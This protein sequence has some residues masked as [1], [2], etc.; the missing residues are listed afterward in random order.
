MKLYYYF[1]AFVFLCF[2]S[3][4]TTLADN[5]KN[6]YGF[7][8]NGAT[9]YHLE[10]G[11]LTNG[12]TAIITASIDGSV[13]CFDPQGKKLW[14]AGTDGGF[15]FDM[16]VADIDNDG[17]DEV[18]VASGNGS[19]YAFNSKGENLWVFSKSAPMYQVSSAK[20][21]DGSSVVVA[22]GVEQILYSLSNQGEVINALNT[23][24][25]IRHIRAGN[26]KNNGQDYIAL[27]TTSSGL[28]GSLSLLLIDPS[29]LSVIWE[30]TDLGKYGHNTGK[31]FFSM[32]ITDTNKDGNEEI[33]LSGGWGEN[34]IVYAYDHKGELLFSESDKIIPK[35]SYRMNLLR[36]VKMPE[37]EFIIGLFG[38]VLIVYE[39]DGTC[40]EVLYGPYSFTDCDF[41]PETKTLFMGSEVSGGDGIYALRLDKSGWQKEYESIRAVGKL[42]VIKQNLE[43][44]KEQITNFKAPDYQPAPRHVDVLSRN[45]G[46]IDYKNITFIA[47]SGFSQEKEENAI[48]CRNPDR[49]APHNLSAEEIVAR[50]AELEKSGQRFILGG[51]HGEGFNYPLSTFER[52]I[53]AAPDH[54]LGFSFSEME[55]TGKSMQE[56]VEKILLP[57]AELCKQH[58]KIIIFQNKNIFWNGSVYLPFWEKIL[59]NERY[60]DVFIPG[61]E[62]TN[63][64]TQELSLSGRIGLWQTGSFDRWSCREITDNANFDRMFEWGGQQVIVHHLRNLVSTTSLG[65]DFLQPYI[66]SGERHEIRDALFEQLVPFYKMLEK[67]IIQIPQKDQLLSLS[68]FALGMKTPPSQT[69]IK[70][71]TNGHKYWYSETSHPEMVFDK[72][73]TYWGGASIA[74]Y[75]FSNYGMHVKRRMCNF[76]PVNPFGLPAIIPAH[77]KHTHRFNQIIETDGQFFYDESGKQFTASEY[78]PIVEKALEEEALKMPVIVK[79]DVHWSVVRIDS[80]HIRITLIDPG[81]LD[82][83]ERQAEIILQHLEGISCTDILSGETLNINKGR[84]T[85]T[86]PAGVFRMLDVKHIPKNSTD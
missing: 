57:L 62:E 56:V 7:S 86:I 38:N 63:S 67:G 77:T 37:D 8:T 47:R 82:P 78:K 43:T 36:H 24:H 60:S 33:L 71:G 18:M 9:V 85:T 69:F 49:R 2:V 54:L 10:T 81:Y 45:P 17:S 46:E 4:N 30:K 55:S 31:R 5:E 34:G 27:A 51:G 83:D 12:K 52:I 44:L 23:T 73:D 13:R 15:P 22:G 11:K 50:V 28:I 26:I 68:G 79:G 21:P 80:E 70:H 61:L 72:L 39:M 20:L 76:L 58:K 65:S 66:F 29:D 32:L 48:W 35:I 6:L 59:L 84:I 3:C 53:E 75:D 19:I 16:C 1:F 14:E 42:A 25:C 41:D 40:R 64:R 74:P